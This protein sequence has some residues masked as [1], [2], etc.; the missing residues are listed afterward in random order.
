V[1][2]TWKYALI[3]G[4]NEST[5][6]YVIQSIRKGHSYNLVKGQGN[7]AAEDIDFFDGTMEDCSGCKLGDLMVFSSNLCILLGDN[8]GKGIK[9]GY[10]INPGEDFKNYFKNTGETTKVT[11]DPIIVETETPKTETPETETSEK[12][13]TPKKN[14]KNKKFEWKTVKIL[15]KWKELKRYKILKKRNYWKH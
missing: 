2:K 10:I 1:E 13:E 6:N 11:F 5:D 8:K 12:T 7:Y 4:S 14:K 15:K 3:S 9:I